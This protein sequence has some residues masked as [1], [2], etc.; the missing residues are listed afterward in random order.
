MQATTSACPPLLACL[1]IRPQPQ[2][3]RRV[4]AVFSLRISADTRQEVVGG[5]NVYAP[6]CRRHYV[7]LSQA[8]QPEGDT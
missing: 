6:V 5:A 8:R 2:E 3:Q 7:Q 4:A 1:P